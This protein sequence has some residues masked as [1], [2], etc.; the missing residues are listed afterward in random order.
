M[1]G[2][3]R[4]HAVYFS[5]SGG[6]TRG[7]IRIIQFGHGR[8]SPTCYNSGTDE[9]GTR[10]NNAAILHMGVATVLRGPWWTGSDFSDVHRIY[11][12]L[13]CGSLR[14]RLSSVHHVLSFVRYR[15]WAQNQGFAGSD[16]GLP[17]LALANRGRKAE[18]VVRYPE[19]GNFAR[20]SA[21]L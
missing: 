17:G 20:T 5:D 12:R 10:A 7:P 14:S 21:V 19:G 3:T 13:P 18:G 6:Y 2:L 16:H 1:S 11:R 15:I 4:Y 9:R 8:S